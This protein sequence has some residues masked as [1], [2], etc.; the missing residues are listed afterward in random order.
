MT[1]HV[2]T[3]PLK[4]IAYGVFV[5]KQYKQFSAERIVVKI[6]RKDVNV[7]SSNEMLK[8]MVLYFHSADSAG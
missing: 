8:L 1:F 4:L 6:P 5:V 7:H 3:N 2:Y